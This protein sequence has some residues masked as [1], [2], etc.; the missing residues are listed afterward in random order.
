MYSDELI[1]EWK[2]KHSALQEKFREFENKYRQ[3]VHS[4]LTEEE[5]RKR[6]FKVIAEK[7]YCNYMVKART[8]NFK[9]EIEE[10]LL[11]FIKIQKIREK[12]LDFIQVQELERQYSNTLFQ[13]RI[14]RTAPS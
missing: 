3:K 14:Q 6:K 13:K 5:K 12:E 8:K 7:S 2:K 4:K 1:K 9:Q 10:E 11:A